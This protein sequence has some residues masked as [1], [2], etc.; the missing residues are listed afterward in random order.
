MYGEQTTIECKT[1]IQALKLV[2]SLER[3]SGGKPPS[4]RLTME[5]F[6]LRVSE[7]IE[8]VRFFAVIFF[9]PIYLGLK[10]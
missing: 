10:L 6:F 8:K 5:S 7:Y 2:S 4:R 3:R 9:S 1:L